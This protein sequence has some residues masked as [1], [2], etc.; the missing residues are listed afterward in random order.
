VQPVSEEL[1]ARRHAHGPQLHVAL[2]E[3]GEPPDEADASAFADAA[4]A[5][6]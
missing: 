5:I 2:F 4:R 1:M 6:W 3:A